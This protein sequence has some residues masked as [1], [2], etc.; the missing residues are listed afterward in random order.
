ME[1]DLDESPPSMDE[2]E[3]DVDPRA[4]ASYTSLVHPISAQCLLCKACYVPPADHWQQGDRFRLKNKTFVADIQYAQL[5]YVRA[6]LMNKR[7]A[8]TI[9]RAWPNTHSKP[10]SGLAALYPC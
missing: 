7:L 1:D 5:Y 4:T 2:M 8:D 3:E 9:R 6:L 10:W